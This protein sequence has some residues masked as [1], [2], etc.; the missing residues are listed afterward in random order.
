MLKLLSVTNMVATQSGGF[1]LF[2]CLLGA[3]VTFVGDAAAKSGTFTTVPI[4]GHSKGII[5][6]VFLMKLSGH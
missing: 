2:T 3:C 6:N 5:F 1:I 4:E